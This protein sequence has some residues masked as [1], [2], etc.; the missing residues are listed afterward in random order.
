MSE[1]NVPEVIVS[2]EFQRITVNGAYFLMMRP[3]ETS[4]WSVYRVELTNDGDTTTLIAIGTFFTSSDAVTA[5]IAY[6]NRQ[7]L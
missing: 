7:G 1:R 5:A 6:T 3:N 4:N 2:G